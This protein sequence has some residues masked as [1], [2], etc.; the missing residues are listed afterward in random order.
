MEDDKKLI[1]YKWVFYVAILLFTA[2]IQHSTIISKIDILGGSPSL[3]L[4]A[5]SVIA[6]LEGANGGA[7][8]GLAAGIIMDAMSSPAEGFYTATY[9]VCGIVSSALNAITYH[10]T[11]FVSLLFWL[12]SVVLSSLL[13]Y[14][15]FML[16]MGKGGPMLILYM[17]PGELLATVLFTPIVYFICRYVYRRFTPDES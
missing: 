2:I 11:Y 1:R 3:L 14:V 15:F 10:K 16:I 9:V 6:M 8:A 17:I 5:V 7:G 4:F 12:A 13:Y